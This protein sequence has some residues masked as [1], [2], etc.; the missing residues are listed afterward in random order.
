MNKLWQYLKKNIYPEFLHFD[1]KPNFYQGRMN[2]R[3]IWLINI[4][5]IS[6]VALMP[7]IILAILN[8]HIT[9]EAIHSEA[10]LRV[11]RLTSNTRRSITYFFRERIDALSFIAREETFNRLDNPD[12]LSGILKSLKIGFGGFVDIGLIDTAG[13]QVQYAGPYN[14]AGKAYA[15]QKWFSACIQNGVVVSDV[16]LGHRN[17]PH[18]V[19][20]VKSPSRKDGFFILRATLDSSHMT[21]ILSSLDISEESDAFISNTEGLLQTA[22]KYNGALLEKIGLPVPSYAEHTRIFETKD[23]NGQPLL[24][25][26]AYIKDSPFILM[27]STQPHTPNNTWHIWRSKMGVFLV[28]AIIFILAII[29]SVPGYTVNRIVESDKRR[30]QAMRHMESDNRLSSIGRLAAG[31]AHEINNPLAIINE[32]AGYI[33]DLFMIEKKFEANQQIMELIDDVIESVERCGAITKQLLG[34]ARHFEPQIIPLELNKVILQVLSFL[35]KEAGYRNIKLNIDVTEDLPVINSD[36]G[37]LQ[38]IFLNLFNNAFQAMADGG[39]LTVRANLRDKDHITVSVQDNGCGISEE[40]KKQIFEPFFSTKAKTGGTGLG[41]SITYGMVNELEGEIS[42]QSEPGMG[43]TF[44]ITLP[45]TLKG[46]NQNECST[47]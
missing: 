19:I 22:S 4:S 21:H 43:T 42:V 27:L 9:Q 38:Q 37:K 34:F 6:F 30:L 15:D 13:Q 11:E 5:L 45:L 16:F 29:A 31:V 3:R 1:Y 18:M 33:K 7:L 17:S 10:K 14:L 8:Y 46:E 12:H 44:F 2:Y 41:L 26:Y 47:G 40:N 28:W 25:G 23:K 35:K 20:A 24:V 39:E 32:N 36:Q